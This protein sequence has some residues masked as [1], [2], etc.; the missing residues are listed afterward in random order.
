M[1]TLM[2]SIQIWKQAR[3]NDDVA[4]TVLDEFKDSGVY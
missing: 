1:N 4:E 3:L 2:R